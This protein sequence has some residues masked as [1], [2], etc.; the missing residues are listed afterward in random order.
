MTTALQPT[1]VTTRSRGRLFF[2]LGIALCLAAPIIYMVQTQVL[3]QLFMPW[4]VLVLTT[5]GVGLMLYAVTRRAGVIRIIC[6]GL[7]ALLC[8][9]EWVF[10]VV[11]SKLPAYEGPARAGE[12]MPAFTTALSD[13]SRLTDKDLAQGRPSVLVFYR[14]HW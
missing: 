10:V 11:L 13:G 7:F 1:P 8:V 5:V 3:K 4:Y 6:L 14:G 2:W 12:K 9:L